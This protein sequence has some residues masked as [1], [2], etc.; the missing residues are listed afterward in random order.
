[1]QTSMLLLA[2]LIIL[3]SGSFLMV[4]Q[5]HLIL[6]KFLSAQL[7]Y[8]AP[9]WAS[10]LQLEQPP[11]SIRFGYHGLP[12][13]QP[14][15]H[16]DPMEDKSPRANTQD[17]LAV[18]SATHSTRTHTASM[19]STSSHSPPQPLFNSPPK[20]ITTSSSPSHP[21]RWL[22]TLQLSMLHSECFQVSFA[23]IA[24]MD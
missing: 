6:H 5:Y 17:R 23:V 7:I 9:S 10:R 21:H 20:S 18:I 13:R 8:K 3:L 16:S 12:F 4:S 19:G 11:P 2:L 22:I 1:M 14:L 15:H 24:E